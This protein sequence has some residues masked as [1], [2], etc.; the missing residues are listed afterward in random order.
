MLLFFAVWLVLARLVELVL[1]LFRFHLRLSS[2][3]GIHSRSDLFLHTRSIECGNG[4][5][6]VLDRLF[7]VLLCRDLL[8]LLCQALF[9]S[10]LL[11]W[12][13]PFRLFLRLH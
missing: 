13:M 9:R 8:C 1:P 7:L 12:R 6:R 2:P 5:R 11:G 3:M 10:D 4:R